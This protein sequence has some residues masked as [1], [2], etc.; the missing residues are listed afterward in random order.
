LT[1]ITPCSFFVD[2]HMGDKLCQENVRFYGN[3]LM[4]PIWEL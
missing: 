3:G 4:V 1:A 2:H